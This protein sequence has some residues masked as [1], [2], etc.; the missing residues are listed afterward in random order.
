MIFK[1]SDF[2][3][4]LGCDGCGFIGPQIER[5]RFRAACDAAERIGWRIQPTDGPGSLEIAKCP[6]CRKDL[7]ICGR[8]MQAPEPDRCAIGDC[9]AR[10]THRCAIRVA[11][12]EC[13]AR[14]C[15]DHEHAPGA[16]HHQRRPEPVSQAI[17]QHRDLLRRV[18]EHDL[19]GGH[20]L[21]NRSL[22]R[23]VDAAIDQERAG[24]EPG[25][26]NKLTFDGEGGMR[27]DLWY[28]RSDG[29]AHTLTLGLVDVRSADDIRISYDFDRDGWVIK[30][31]S[32]FEW[33]RD[34]DV[35]DGDF[36]EVAFVQA[37]AR[38][39]VPPPEE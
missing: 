15:N 22:A 9:A 4:F 17:C 14:L 19:T 18:R 12:I 31:A 29:S 10:Y 33:A 20:S 26:L 3:E 23:E 28:P 30:Q 13:R 21:T 7:S 36:Q 25:P 16:I 11:G 1:R 8:D 24:D 35:R 6:R 27:T 37:W 2:V 34:D 38:Q 5:E 39:C 32:V